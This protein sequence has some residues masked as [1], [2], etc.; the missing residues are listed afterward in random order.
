[1]AWRGCLPRKQG[2]GHLS[3][4]WLGEGPHKAQ[5]QSCPWDPGGGEKGV[6][7]QQPVEPRPGWIPGGRLAP[8]EPQDQP[9][10]GRSGYLA[11]TQA[12]GLW[13]PSPP[14]VVTGD[15]GEAGLCQKLCRACG[16]S[17]AACPQSLPRPPQWA[18]TSSR[19]LKGS[20][21]LTGRSPPPPGGGPGCSWGILG[22]Q[23][24]HPLLGPWGASRVAPGWAS[25]LRARQPRGRSGWPQAAPRGSGPRAETHSGFLHQNESASGI[26]VLPILN[27]PP[28]SP[29]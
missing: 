18:P 17:T 16:R 6:L 23:A 28:S 24:A 15:P 13:L 20:L 26:H 2:R 4:L 22:A 12:Q 8:A 14:A 5:N 10:P 3:A 7:S 11:P 27:P 25:C 19:L 21:S 1:M 29:P 9:C